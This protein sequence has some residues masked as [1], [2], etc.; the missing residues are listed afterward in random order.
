LQKKSPK[1][2]P[3][4]PVNFLLPSANFGKEIPNGRRNEGCLKI[5][6]LH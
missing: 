6:S 2:F 5:K 3:R 1:D 4:G